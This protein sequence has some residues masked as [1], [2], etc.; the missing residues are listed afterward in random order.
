M[1]LDYSNDDVSS[2]R[3]TDDY[4]TAAATVAD[5]DCSSD[6]AIVGIAIAADVRFRNRRSNYVARTV[7]Y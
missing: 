4:L 5:V 3:G 6:V 7:N 1:S 2:L